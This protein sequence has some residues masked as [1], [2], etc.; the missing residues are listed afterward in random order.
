MVKTYIRAPNWSTAPPPHGPLRLG[1]LLPSVEEFLPI[2][3]DHIV[4][5]LNENPTDIKEGFKLNLSRAEGGE[6]GVFAKF[7]ALAGIGLDASI[8][9]ENDR[10]TE[11]EFKAFETFSFNPNENYIRQVAELEEVKSYFHSGRRGIPLYLVTGIKVGREGQMT[12]S[13]STTR[14]TTLEL[15]VSAPEVPVEVGPKASFNRTISS[16]LSYASSSDFIVAFQVRK[17]R[18]RKGGVSHEMFRKNAELH[19]DTQAIS[20]DNKEACW[21]LEGSDSIS[22]LDFVQTSEIWKGHEAG[23]GCIEEIKW[24]LP[25]GE[26]EGED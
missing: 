24:I 8:N 7:L 6:L 2:N 20:S 3:S 13:T 10:T 19:G 5:I 9:I 16:G 12:I 18:M 25:M 1:H 14:G 23:K 22:A 4:P 21:E 11:L 26:D 17:L 15:G